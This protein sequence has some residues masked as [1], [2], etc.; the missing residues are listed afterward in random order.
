MSL[1]NILFEG[2]SILEHR[3]KLF[4]SFS[5][6]FSKPDVKMRGRQREY[7]LKPF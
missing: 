2:K 5:V 1:E 3:F 6:I 7:C 4:K